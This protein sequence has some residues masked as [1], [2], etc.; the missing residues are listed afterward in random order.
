MSLTS[1][2]I[3]NTYKDILTIS[4][5][6]DNEGI[7][8]ANKRLFDGNGTGSPLWIGT[9]TLEM[10]GVTT[11]SGTLILTEKSSEP[12]SPTL[13]SLAFINDDLYIAKQS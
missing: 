3:A 5:G 7:T 10:T 11:I 8:T 12:S 9:N 2:T 1:K 6:T 13:G 4:S